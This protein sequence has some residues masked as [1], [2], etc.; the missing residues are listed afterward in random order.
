L[1]VKFNGRHN[2]PTG[3]L[4]N[5]G[6]EEESSLQFERDDIY[7]IRGVMLGNVEKFSSLFTGIACHQSGADQGA[8]MFLN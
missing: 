2:L 7:F 3:I 6:P 4:K 1:A 8:E 5:H